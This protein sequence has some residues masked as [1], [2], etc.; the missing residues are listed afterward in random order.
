MTS[1]ANI[2][3][4]LLIC[5][6]VAATMLVNVEDNLMA[7]MGFINNYLLLALAVMFITLLSTGINTFVTAVIILFS[8]NANMPAGFGLNLGLDRDIYAL[9]MV[10]LLMTSFAWTVFTRRNSPAHGSADAYAH[11]DDGQ[12]SVV[13]GS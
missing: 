10:I 5:I 9:G 12:L 3:K 11:A 8:M 1:L 13:A 2:V 4:S 7:R 6:I